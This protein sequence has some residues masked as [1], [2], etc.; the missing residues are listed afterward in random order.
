[1]SRKSDLLT[2]PLMKNH[3]HKSSRHFV[4]SLSKGLDILSLFSRD[5]IYLGNEEISKRTGIPK[6]TVTRLTFT[7]T[8]TRHLVYDSSIRKYKI[9]PATMAWSYASSDN[10]FD[11]NEAK[12]FLQDFADQMGCSSAALSVNAGTDMIYVSYCSG[13]SVLQVRTGVGARLKLWSTAAGRAYWSATTQQQ[14]DSIESEIKRHVMIEAA[15]ALEQLERAQYEYETSGFCT[16][17]GDWVSGV[18]A[19]ACPVINPSDDSIMYTVSCS[20]TESQFSRSVV[21]SLI[22]PK[23]LEFSEFLA[24]KLAR[25]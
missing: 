7:L 18:N 1:M 2:N 11:D 24:P 10:L 16:S 8:T 3:D 9:G 12:N 19:V 21:D 6:S 4:E 5:V 14:R 23:L 15:N 25:R 17:F 20:G 13:P 22:G